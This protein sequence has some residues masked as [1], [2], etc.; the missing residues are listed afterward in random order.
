MAVFL[1]SSVFFFPDTEVFSVSLVDVFGGMLIVALRFLDSSC[2]MHD[3]S[4]P[5]TR[6]LL[7]IC[8]FICLVSY[9]VNFLFKMHHSLQFLTDSFHIA[10]VS[11]LGGSAFGLWSAWR[12]GDFWRFGDN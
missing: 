9:F 10:Q 8:L 11:S 7:F 5:I 3:E 12:Y 6:C 2:I 1:L 4:Y